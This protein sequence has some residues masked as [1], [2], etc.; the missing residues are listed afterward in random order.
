MSA[1]SSVNTFLLWTRFWG[2]IMETKFLV[3][4]VALTLLMLFASFFKQGVFLDLNFCI[5]LDKIIYL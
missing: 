4:M 2:I 3:T 5:Q 1:F